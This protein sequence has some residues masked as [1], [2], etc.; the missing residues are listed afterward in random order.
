LVGEVDWVEFVAAADLEYRKSGT[1]FACEC[2]GLAVTLLFFLFFFCGR[3]LR[4]SHLAL[5][6]L[7]IQADARHA[8]SS[9]AMSPMGYGMV[10]NGMERPSRRVMFTPRYMLAASGNCKLQIGRC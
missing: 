3:R 2:F 8:L 4:L 9:T 6:S 1:Y 10:W 5:V 7:M